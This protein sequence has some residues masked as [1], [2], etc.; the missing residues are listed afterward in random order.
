[1][2]PSTLKQTRAIWTS[3]ARWNV[4][5]MSMT[6]KMKVTKEITAAKNTAVACNRWL[7]RFFGLLTGTRTPITRLGGGR[8][9]LLSYKEKR[10]LDRKSTRLNSSHVRISYAVFC[11]KKKNTYII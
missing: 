2:S 10:T 9:I 6:K 5:T 11:L 7:H 3:N 4:T 1:M 8:S